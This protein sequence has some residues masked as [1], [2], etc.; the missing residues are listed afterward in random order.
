MAQW[1]RTHTAPSRGPQ[2]W[3]PAPMLGKIT[4][5]SSSSVS[6]RQCIRPSQ[7]PAFVGVYLCPQAYSKSIK[8]KFMKC[9]RHKQACTIFLGVWCSIHPIMKIDVIFFSFPL[10]LVSVMVGV[11]PQADPWACFLVE[12]STPASC[13]SMDSFLLLLHFQFTLGAHACV[14]IVARMHT[15]E[16]KTTC[17]SHFSLSP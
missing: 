7:A 4:T 17:G 10:L 14:W 5:T 15:R 13:L 1:L 8:N 9:N 16:V 2:V 6:G 11:T 3:F 12:M